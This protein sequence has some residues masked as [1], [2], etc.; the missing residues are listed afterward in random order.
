[1][2]TASFKGVPFFV[3]QRGRSCGRRIVLHQYPKRDLPYGEDMGREVIRYQI[4]GYLVQSAFD[5]SNL[6]GSDQPLKDYDV[7]RDLLTQALDEEGPGR[8]VDPYNPDMRYIG[9]DFLFHCERYQLTEVRERGG[10]C[11]FDMLFTEAGAPGGFG[12]LVGAIDTSGVAQG[13]ASTLRDNVIDS[14]N[15]SLAGV[16]A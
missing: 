2:K 15:A 4:I 16:N 1:M 14:I 9:Y 5:R 13:S 10:Y 3:E 6:F 12:P 7:A 8:L 11:Q